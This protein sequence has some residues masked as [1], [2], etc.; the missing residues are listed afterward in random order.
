MLVLKQTSPTAAPAAPMP[1]P[2]KMLPSART[3]AA[4]VPGGRGDACDIGASVMRS[5]NLGLSWGGRSAGAALRPDNGLEIAAGGGC[6]KRQ[7]RRE[8]P[9]DS[10]AWISTGNCQGRP[11]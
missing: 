3:R 6:V 10:I 4:V 9:V 1:R 8:I 11:R 7:A 5:R 2:Q